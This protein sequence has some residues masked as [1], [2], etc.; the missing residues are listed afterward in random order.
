MTRTT[1]ELVNEL[2]DVER[3]LAID[4]VEGMPRVEKRAVKEL[5]D[6][7]GE[8]SFEFSDLADQLANEE[9][10]REVSA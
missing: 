7:C 1:M 5:I 3:I 4:G 2:R 9:W 8:V 6:L 10:E